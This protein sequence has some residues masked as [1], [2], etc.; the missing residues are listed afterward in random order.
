MQFNE[1][2]AVKYMIILC[3]KQ[4]IITLYKFHTRM[5]FTAKQLNKFTEKQFQQLLN[6]TT[7]IL[8]HNLIKQKLL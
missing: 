8:Q 7:I 2:R 6:K 1:S 4:K 5:N 3:V